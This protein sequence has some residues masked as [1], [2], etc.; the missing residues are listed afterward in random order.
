MSTT[1]RG[2]ARWAICCA[3]NFWRCSTRSYRTW[4]STCSRTWSSSRGA[5][6]SGWRK[7]S[8]KEPRGRWLPCNVK[9]RSWKERRSNYYRRRTTTTTSSTICGSTVNTFSMQIWMS[10]M[11][12]ESAYSNPTPS[13]AQAITKGT[14]K[15]KTTRTL[16]THFRILNFYM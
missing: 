2:K 7:K 9:W 3:A 6:S 10:I 4:C 5:S 16:C 15:V 12:S 8:E 11:S 13:E 1:L 14:V